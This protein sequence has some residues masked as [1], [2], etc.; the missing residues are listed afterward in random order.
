MIFDIGDLNISYR[1]LSFREKISNINTYLID[2]DSG[3]V[4][5]VQFNWVFH[6]SCI[7]WTLR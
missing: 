6:L 2:K 4:I 1:E 5:N 7:K 3:H